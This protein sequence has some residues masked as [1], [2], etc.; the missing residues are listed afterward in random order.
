MAGYAKSLQKV[1]YNPINLHQ[2]C[3]SM[4]KLQ[5][6]NFLP[7]LFACLKGIMEYFLSMITSKK[8]NFK[9]IRKLPLIRYLRSSKDVV[10]KLF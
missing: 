5:D 7:K 9:T 6:F 10:D 1:K 3:K 8:L 2:D 4:V